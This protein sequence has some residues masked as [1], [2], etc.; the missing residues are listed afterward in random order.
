[1]ILRIKIYSF[2]F[3]LLEFD[4]ENSEEKCFFKKAKKGPKSFMMHMRIGATP[5]EYGNQ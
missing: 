5:T 2:Y 1:M 3:C 4:R